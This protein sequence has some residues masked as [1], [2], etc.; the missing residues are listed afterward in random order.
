MVGHQVQ[1]KKHSEVWNLFA[2]VQGTKEKS[3]WGTIFLACVPIETGICLTVLSWF[4]SNP[5]GSFP[6]SF[7]GSSSSPAW[8]ILKGPGFSYWSPFLLYLS[9]SI[10]DLIQLQVFTYLLMTS[11]AL[12]CLLVSCIQLPIE[13][14]LLEGI[15][16][17][18]S[19]SSWSSPHL[20]APPM[21][22]FQ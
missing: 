2:L 6:G 22:F 7:A 11:R 19:M 21:A 18:P 4:S 15:L 14:L 3:Y 13:Q 16:N 20:P 1:K 9:S 12:T 10:L 17:M 8:L 5:A